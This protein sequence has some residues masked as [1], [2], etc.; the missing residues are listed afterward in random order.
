MRMSKHIENV[1]DAVQGAAATHLYRIAQEAL[2][3]VLK[4]SGAQTCNVQLERDVRCVRL[5][6]TDDGVGFAPEARDPLH[7][8]HGLGM[9]SM[10][11]R[12]R[13]LHAQFDLQSAPGH[14]TAV[15]VELPIDIGASTLP[16]NA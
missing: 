16:G 8:A 2:N 4:H 11:E 1:D 14:G 10:F 5:S 7:D 12:A 13:I 3:N 9:A 6:V 15:R